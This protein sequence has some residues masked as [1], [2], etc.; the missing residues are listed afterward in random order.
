MLTNKSWIDRFDLFKE[1][2]NLHRTIHTAHVET[3]YRKER[4]NN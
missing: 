4:Q 1:L 2:T 3:G